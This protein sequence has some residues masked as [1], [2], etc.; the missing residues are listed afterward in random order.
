LNAHAAAKNQTGER[1]DQ[2]LDKY[3]ADY[4]GTRSPV[5]FIIVFVGYVAYHRIRTLGLRKRFAP[6]YDLAVLAHG[7]ARGAEEKL[8]YAPVG[9]SFPPFS[10]SAIKASF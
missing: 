8:V 3:D 4:C 7:P 5:A 9:R 6:K 10:S 2:S 1:N